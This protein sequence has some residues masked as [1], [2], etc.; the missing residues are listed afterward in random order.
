MNVTTLLKIHESYTE[1][2]THT[3]EEICICTRSYTILEIIYVVSHSWNSDVLISIILCD[4]VQNAFL[5]CIRPSK[6]S[7]N[8][9]S[10]IIVTFFSVTSLIL[11]HT[12]PTFIGPQQG[13]SL[14]ILWEKEKMLWKP[15]FFL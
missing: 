13:R 7:H 5:G 8:F 2:M 10:I 9:V 6:S 3:T 11:Y 1:K 12:I 14:K 15:V 4:D